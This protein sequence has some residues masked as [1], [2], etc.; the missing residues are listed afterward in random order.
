MMKNLFRI[1]MNLTLH[2]PS[3]SQTGLG[4]AHD[5]VWHEQVAS[6]PDPKGS[7]EQTGVVAGQGPL[8]LPQTHLP[9]T[10]RFVPNGVPQSIFAQ[11]SKVK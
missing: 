1:E 8:R 7:F 6:S 3:E 4:S 10:Q 5:P 2:L 11:G 9:S